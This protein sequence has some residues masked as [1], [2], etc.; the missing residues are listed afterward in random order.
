MYVCDR[1][2]HRI[3]VFDLDLNFIRSIGSYGKGRGEFDAPYDVQFD[4]N[5]YMYVVEFSNKRVQVLDRSGHFYTS[6]W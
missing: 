2:N 6:V 1:N 3:Q 5:G 4:A